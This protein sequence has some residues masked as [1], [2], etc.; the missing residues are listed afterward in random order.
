VVFAAGS[1]GTNLLLANCKHGG[2]LPRI[3]D[4]LGES[5]AHQQRV[6]P[7]GA[8]AEDRKTWNDVAISCSIHVDHDTHIEFVNYGRN[9]TSCRCCTPCWS[10]RAVG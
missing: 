3:S 8:P 7:D 10:A 4:R 6:D 1:L 2:S 9:A 5:G